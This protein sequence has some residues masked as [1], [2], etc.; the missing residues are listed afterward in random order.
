MRCTMAPVRGPPWLSRT[1]RMILGFAADSLSALF[2]FDSALA[3]P[4]FPLGPSA[5]CN[6][7]ELLPLTVHTPSAS[8]A[9]VLLFM[10]T[11]SSPMA[12]VLP[13]PAAAVTAG[14]GEGAPPGKEG[15]GVGAPPH[16]R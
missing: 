15:H 6:F 13:A 11:A 8:T 16:L 7:S 10:A 9:T 2:A 14:V 12:T 5:S 1:F 4:F 3:P